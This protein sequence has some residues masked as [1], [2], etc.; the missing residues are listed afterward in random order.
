MLNEVTSGEAGIDGVPPDECRPLRE[1]E[2]A[3]V[4][5]FH[6]SVDAAAHDDL[7]RMGKPGSYRVVRD[8]EALPR[9]L[10][11][12]AQRLRIG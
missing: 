6:L 2:Q 9:E 5:H 7:R 4:G 11:R 8:V 3:G 12:L 10:L 1:A